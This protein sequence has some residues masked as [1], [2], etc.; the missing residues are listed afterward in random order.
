MAET[1]GGRGGGSGDHSED[2]PRIGEAEIIR[3]QIG[4]Q[5][6]EGSTTGV[7]AGASSSKGG[8]D[9]HATK[10]GVGRDRST[11]GSQGHTPMGITTG[12]PQVRRLDSRSCVEGLVVTGLGSV[13]ASGSG[14]GGGSG[15]DRSGLP[16]KDPASGKDPMV[17]E[18]TQRAA[19]V[20]RVE[21]IPHVGSS[22]HDPITSSDLAEFMCEAALARLM[23]PYGGRDGVDS[24]GR[25]AAADCRGQ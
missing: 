18:E 8:G 10:G 19:H 21:F 13:G 16:L 20:E 7:S 6:T 3:S 11:Q 2:R 9:G 12:G 15:D 25:A 14:S 5:T 4:D 1:G 23:L 17:V 22:R 24:P